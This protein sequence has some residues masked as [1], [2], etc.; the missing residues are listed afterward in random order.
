VALR[1]AYAATAA[2]G[3]TFWDAGEFVAAFASFGVPHPPGTPLFVALGRA[4]TAV[5]AWG[6][7][8]VAP[9]A[10]LLSAACTAAAGGVTA[11]LAARWTGSARAGV[12]AA[13]CAGGMS[14][15]WANATEAEVYAPALLLSLAAVAAGD[16]AG[17]G[18]ARGEAAG[19]GPAAPGGARAAVCTA[20]ALGLA[21][22]VHLSALVAAPAAAWLAARRATAG[23]GA[24]VL[25]SRLLTLAAA[26]ATAAGVGSGRPGL[27]LAGLAMLGGV[28]AWP[29]A[30]LPRGAAP[31][32]RRAARL[33]AVAAAA[34]T[35]AATGALAMLLVRARH[36][37]W[38]NQGDPSTWAALADVVARRQYAPAPPWPRQA[39]WWLQLA[40]LGEW[41]DWQVALGMAPGPAPSWRRTPL[42]LVYAALGV[43]G[44]AWHRRRDRRSF[45]AWAALLA[46]GSVGVAA[47]LNL[48]AGPTFGDGVLAADAPREARERDYFFALGWW[49]W[50][51]WAGM[52]AV[53]LARRIAR[54]PGRPGRVGAAAGLAVAA[55]PF[56]FN[57]PAATRRREPDASTADAFARALL[58]AAPPRAVLLV[59]ADNDSY[60]LWAAQ[61]ADRVRR[62][63][64]VVTLSLLP[65][66]WYRGELARRHALL[67][68]GAADSAWAGDRATVRAIAVAA[69]AQGRPV[70]ASLA[71]G[72][73]RL[74]AAG[75]G[76]W[77]HAG[78]LVAPVADGVGGGRLVRLPAA[79]AARTGVDWADTA[80]VA[81]AAR[82]VARVAPRT[83]AAPPA[84]GGDGVAAWARRQLACPAALDAAVGAAPG[85]A[86]AAAGAARVEGACEAR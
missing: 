46:C 60:P 36:D 23:P 82:L 52:G 84:S 27:A 31:S 80:A 22:P 13:L 68:P 53:V 64:T 18:A 25:R 44:G 35:L 21:A 81:A 83:L 42:T 70:V 74:A 79:L 75:T 19:D 39:P 1:A 37:P 8:G 17:R 11:A 86:P 57:W 14:T 48:K 38:L 47:Y 56:A 7:V 6:G 78:V 51:A 45:G 69:A 20:Y 55:L 29:G 71:V 26:A 72:P 33:G 28:A 2:P 3:A 85:A 12:A 63:V 16:A 73:E 49:A 76:R 5:A 32:A 61:A 9:A 24:G 4:W 54:A 50:G 58:L 66:A 34:A 10:A 41:A 62:D 30:A 43:V 59:R 15:A 40:N 65:A 77:V 67:A